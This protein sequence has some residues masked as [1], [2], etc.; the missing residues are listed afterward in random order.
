MCI[1]THKEVFICREI[2]EVAEEWAAS[3]KQG[4][5]ETALEECR[6]QGL[7]DNLYNRF[8]THLMRLMATDPQIFPLSI[9]NLTWSAWRH[10]LRLGSAQWLGG[11]QPDWAN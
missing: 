4:M 1:A 3:G 8:N 2:L 10:A 6:C 9:H 11:Q 7:V 5:M